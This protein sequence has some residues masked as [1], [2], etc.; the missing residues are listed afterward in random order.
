MK[1]AAK[2]LLIA[3]ACAFFAGLCTRFFRGVMALIICP[4]M[5]A[6]APAPDFREA[7]WVWADADGDGIELADEPGSEFAFLRRT[8]D[9]PEGSVVTRAVLSLTADDSAEAWINGEPAAKSNV[10]WRQSA[11]V[12]VGQ[13]LR[14]GK[15]VIAVR[16]RNTRLPRDSGGV[17]CALAVTYRMAD[18]KESEWVIGSD[19]SWQGAPD[20][21]EGWEKA[22]FSDVAWRP[23]VA[24]VP[25]GGAPWHNHFTGAE[26]GIVGEFPDFQIE[27]DGKLLAPLR[28][29]LKRHYVPGISCALWDPWLP[30]SLLWVGRNP[31]KIDAG[32][33]RFYR[34]SFLGREITAEGYAEVRQHRGLG[35]PEGWPFPL[36]M[37]GPGVGWHFSLAGNPYGHPHYGIKREVDADGWVLEGAT[38]ESFDEL[39]GWTIGLDKANAAITSPACEAAKIMAPYIRLE[40]RASGLPATAQPYLEWTTEQQP[41]F[42]PERRICFSPIQAADGLQ[43]T[44]LPLHEIPGW[45][46]S[47]TRFRI[48]FDNPSGAKVGIV[49][50]FSAQDSRLPI[51]NP[52]FILGSTDF[53]NLSG[54]LDF[55]RLQINRLRMAMGYSLKEFGVEKNGIAYVPWPGHEGRSGITWVDG[56]KVLR[57]GEGVGNNYY[58]LLPFGAWDAYLNIRIYASLRAMAKLEK[59]IESTPQWNLPGSP[60]RRSAAELDAIAERLRTEF[61][62]KFWNPAAGRFIGAIDVDGVVRDYGFTPINIEAVVYGLASEEQAK[63]IY[64]WLDGERTVDGDTSVGADIYH[65]RFAPRSTT[66]RNTDY[67]LAAWSAPESIPFGDQIQDGGAVLGFSYYD[68]MARIQTLGPDDAWKRLKAILD[69][70]QEV[71]AYGGYRKYYEDH[72]GVLQGGGPP[73][74]LGLD[75]EFFES[76]MLPSVMVYGFLGL[77]ATPTG[78]IAKPQ[79]PAD[80]PSLTVTNISYRSWRFDIKADAGGKTLH[81]TVH[82]GDPAGLKIEMPNG[83]KFQI[84]NK[85]TTMIN[86]SDNRPTARLRLD[87]MDEGIVFRHGQGPE[88]YDA[89]GVRE[90]SVVLHDGIYHLFYDGAEPGVGWLACLATSTDMKNWQRHGPVFSYGEPGTP[91]SH[92]ATSPWFIHED[93]LW[94]AFYV[95]CSKTTPPPDCIPH[96]P[97][98]T[99]KAEAEN[100]R[101]PWKKR[102]D[103]VAVTAE[104]GTYRGETASPGFLFRHDGQLRMFFS[105]AEGEV[106][107]TAVKIKR[108]LGMASAPHPDGPWTV[109]DQP[110]LPI[111]EQI[112]NSSLYY[113]P[114]NQTWFLFTNHIGIND[115]GGEYTDAIWVYWSKDPLKWN[116]E[117]KAV[118]LDGKNC[119]WSKNCLGMP[120]VLPVGDRLAIFYDAPGGDSVSHMGR[121]IGLAWLPLPLTPPA[122]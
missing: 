82:K 119:T 71:Q 98:V 93:G 19:S 72:D 40:W 45:E 113:E 102:Y 86:Y 31:G 122:P 3:T 83:W 87:A 20:A 91:D 105:S 104:P 118:V 81:V 96:A 52:D 109:P 58:D 84:D 60:L 39:T 23:A 54:D 48:H 112:E 30:R 11:A 5:A 1:P 33:R 50:L 2:T 12:E 53:F 22:G 106:S 25:L 44:M 101:G 57:P 34:N 95:G 35:L 77:E 70:Y 62:K 59:A 78:L 4:L 18:G 38:T 76:V 79:L 74:G 7:S 49:A 21:P 8:F 85:D 66:L 69:W 27:G 10:D 108:T 47:I 32:T 61:Q 65:W 56:K 89:G 80:W 88:S 36:W 15:N 28:D 26:V 120:S 13:W 117:D 37:Q 46:G 63:M 29:L 64:Q 75:Q 94:H 97:Y 14:P 43:F 16:A 42:S 99:C 41:E 90:A 121:D 55:L 114:S 116:A 67:Y 9:L 6:A 92:T 110:I 17:I 51:T 68:I 73:G 100:L 24:L 103:V 107:D 115:Q 111:E